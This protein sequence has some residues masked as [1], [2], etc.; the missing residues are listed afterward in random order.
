MPDFQKKGFGT[1]IM[2]QLE[3]DIGKQY[4]KAEIDASLPACKLYSNRGYKTIDYGI[5]ECAGD[6]IQV[7]EIME[8]K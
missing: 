4:D 2:N 5:W 1:F 3:E 6:V 8:K 7:Y